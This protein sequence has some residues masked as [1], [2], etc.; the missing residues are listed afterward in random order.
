[1]H[2][3]TAASTRKLSAATIGRSDPVNGT[4]EETTAPAVYRAVADLHTARIA[5]AES[6]GH[7]VER[8]SDV[9]VPE[10]DADDDKLA[11][12]RPVYDVRFADGIAEETLAIERV[13]ERVNS[14][15]DRLGV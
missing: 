9:L 11:T 2:T 5:L 6:I 8:L 14:V 1:V 13:T 3:R 10:G 4:A 15:I 12:L 7:L